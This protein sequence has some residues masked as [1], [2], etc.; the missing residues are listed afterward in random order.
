MTEINAIRYSIPA[1]RYADAI[2][3]MGISREQLDNLEN[4]FRDNPD[5]FND[6]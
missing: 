1:M 6:M 4:I 3:E 5:F 2:C